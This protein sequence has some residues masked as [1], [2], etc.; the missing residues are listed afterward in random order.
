MFENVPK[1]FERK[2]QKQ[3]PPSVFSRFRYWNQSP[4]FAMFMVYI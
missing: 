1:E 3:G 2:L 4:F